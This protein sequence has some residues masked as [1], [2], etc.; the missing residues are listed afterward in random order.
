M[1]A[2]ATG[3]PNECTSL[4]QDVPKVDVQLYATPLGKMATAFSCGNYKEAAVFVMSYC[5]A[6]DC[7]GRG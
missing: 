3:H 2:L 7:K 6:D 4:L 1:R 5:C